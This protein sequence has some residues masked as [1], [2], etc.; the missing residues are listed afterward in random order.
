[1]GFVLFSFL[2]TV[3]YNKHRGELDEFLMASLVHSLVVDYGLSYDDIQ[4]AWWYTHAEIKSMEDTTDF[5]IDKYNEEDAK[6][7]S[8]IPTESKINLWEKIVLKLTEK[9]SVEMKMLLKNMGIK[10]NTVAILAALKYFDDQMVTTADKQEL[11]EWVASLWS[12]VTDLELD[13]MST[14]SYD[15]E[16]L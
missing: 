10:D 4:N 7:I 12:S 11:V 15:F 5:D 8:T 16:S 6:T 1:M 3:S 9:Q 13:S 2:K 14:D